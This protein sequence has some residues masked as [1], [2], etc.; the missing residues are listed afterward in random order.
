[1]VPTKVLSDDNF[2]NL[3]REQ[4]HARWTLLVDLRSEFQGSWGAYFFIAV[5]ITVAVGA[6]AFFGLEGFKNPSILSVALLYG[7][8]VALL[9]VSLYSYVWFRWIDKRFRRVNERLDKMRREA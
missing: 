1:M 7:L 2:D 8:V 5:L 4:L 9:T 3:S 6:G